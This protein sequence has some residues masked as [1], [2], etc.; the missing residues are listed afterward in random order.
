MFLFY[1]VLR[2]LLPNFFM[3]SGTTMLLYLF[4]TH[5]VYPVKYWRICLHISLL[6]TSVW[7]YPWYIVLVIFHHHLF[8]YHNI[9]DYFN[10]TLIKSLHSFVT[11]S[12]TIFSICILCQL[13]LCLLF[14]SNTTGQSCGYY[15]KSRF[16]SSFHLN[17]CTFISLALL[18]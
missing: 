14:F 8:L 18:H 16:Y 13:R 11:L 1:A 15:S 3:A 10:T 7:I 12:Y 17:L 4:L 6:N 9:D 2:G 5:P